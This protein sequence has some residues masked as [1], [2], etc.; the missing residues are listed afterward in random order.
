[1][2][3]NER[4]GKVVKWILLI[5]FCSTVNLA[6]G[7]GLSIAGAYQV[8]DLVAED[9]EIITGDKRLYNWSAG[10]NS[11]VSAELF[12]NADVSTITDDPLNPGILISFNDG[13]GMDL[14]GSDAWMTFS[15]ELEVLGGGMLL[16][17]IAARFNFTQGD[18]PYEE[19]QEI[20]INHPTDGVLNEFGGDIHVEFT[21]H[22]GVFQVKHE[23]GIIDD[24]GLSYG[25]LH[26]VWFEYSQIP[27]GTPVP[28]PTTIAL[29]GLGLVGLAG[30]ELRR[31]RKKKTIN[32]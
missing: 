8:S 13:L 2:A 1:M 21:P 16:H 5:V 9:G 11:A 14:L 4:R 18:Y 10:H 20:T 28:E 15:Y 27:T 25:T 6:I 29:L 24:D 12:I 32:S 19:S 23:W 7:Q 17:D 3:D 22:E 30:A 31:R 26:S